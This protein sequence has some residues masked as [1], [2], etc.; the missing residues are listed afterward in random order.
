MKYAICFRR[1]CDRLKLLA[2]LL[3]PVLFFSL[4]FLA[5]KKPDESKLIDGVPLICQYPSYPTGCESVA[6]VTLLRYYG[7]SID[8]PTYIDRYLPMAQTPTKDSFGASPAQFFLGDPRSESGWGCWAPVIE[9]G[10]NE[11]LRDAG[12]K[13]LQAKTLR[14]V[15]L[16]QLC[17]EYL[18]Q[19]KPVL[20]WATSAMAKAKRG[21]TW[22]TELGD[23]TWI[24]PMHCLTLIGYDE[25]CYYFSDPQTGTL[26]PYAKKSV[27]DAYAS[28]GWQAVVIESACED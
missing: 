26:V 18:E 4:F 11:A 10:L 20:L 9:K 14:F 23:C 8:I 19:N 27:Q 24:S 12:R 25:T 2:L 15:P 6:A 1:R 22:Q 28:L 16:E 17:R 3:I 5:G 7:I 21:I 13:D